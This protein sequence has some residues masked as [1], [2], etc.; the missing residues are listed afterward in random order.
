MEIMKNK[1]GFYAVLVLLLFSSAI[2]AQQVDLSKGHLI[3]LDKGLQIQAQVFPVLSDTGQQVGVDLTRWD[4]SNFTTLNFQWNCGVGYMGA[5]G[6]DLQWARWIHDSSDGSLLSVELPYLSQAVGF[7]VGDEQTLV[8]GQM[9]AI[10]TRMAAISQLY[11]DQI[12]YTNQSPLF[13]G[14]A[15]TPITVNLL[16]EYM[17]AANPDMLSFS[18][19]PFRFED[20][21]T[22]DFEGGSPTEMYEHMEVYRTASLL[23]NDGTSTKPIPFGLYVEAYA[24]S[25][26]G[27]NH[28]Q[29]SESQ[30]RLE[31]FSAWAFGAKQVSA[32]VYD[33]PAETSTIDPLLFNGTGDSSPTAAFYQYAELNRQSR[34]IGNTLVRLLNTDVQMVRGAHGS[35]TLNDLPA[36]VP[37]WSSVADPYITGIS[38]TNQG[39]LNDG[40]R[41]DV[42]VGYFRPLIESLDGAFENEIYF[43]IV[44]GLADWEGT[45]AETQQMIHL[46][47]DFLDS[48]IT[49]LQRVSRETGLVELVDLAH[50][51]GSLYHLDLL[52][53]GGTGDL[54]KFNTGAAF[55]GEMRWFLPG[56]A[57]GDGV[58]SAGDYAAVQANFG[59]TI[60]TSSTSSATP[61][62]ATMS[63]LAL[64]CM[65][66]VRRRKR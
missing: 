47:F 32:F 20:M 22:H 4:Q 53:D 11:P 35:G 5:P 23:G 65:M 58:V 13:N 60:L 1:F 29:P 62:P 14:P 42:V 37:E 16:Q 61:E 57:N 39:T 52:L 21:P 51:G 49:S 9:G 2:F 28:R 25:R 15:N 45:A 40:L 19:Y 12:I 63:L 27:M 36:G 8:S 30:F 34:N 48:G 55:V 38:A 24:D 59:N 50:D 18:E 6:S 46:D 43:M 41:G 3:L 7:Q 31:Q 17:G 66:I 26:A 33:A 64:G 54:F 56:D 10:A 44:N